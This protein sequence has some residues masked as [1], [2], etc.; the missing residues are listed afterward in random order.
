[1]TE[2]PV[3]YRYY[4]VVSG[5]GLSVHVAKW[6]GVERTRKSWWVVPNWMRDAP[7]QWKGSRKR[8][9]DYDM[10][11]GLIPPRRWAYPTEEHALRSYL[12]RKRMQAAHGTQTVKRA[13]A[14]I[15]AAT[16]GLRRLAQGEEPFPRD[17]VVSIP[18]E[19]DMVV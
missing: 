19:V 2:R 1:M 8:V 12:R 7:D 16:E 6:I 17:Y 14:G 10:D 11:A 9:E 3:F 15:D 13:S 4:D 5:V 18:G